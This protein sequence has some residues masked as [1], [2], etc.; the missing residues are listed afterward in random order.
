MQASYNSEQKFWPILY[1][2]LRYKTCHRHLGHKVVISPECP[3][4][5]F[6]PFS[7]PFSG[8][9]KWFLNTSGGGP[10]NLK[11]PFFVV[12]FFIWRNKKLNIIES[13][14]V[15]SFVNEI[16]RYIIMRL[17]LCYQEPTEWVRC[18]H[19]T[20]FVMKTCAHHWLTR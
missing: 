2:Y 11:N 13:I 12:L 20:A 1:S 16:Q 7:S 6:P 5:Y 8:N 9:L 3:F 14:Y 10:W 19:T 15:G 18:R 17:S 4:P